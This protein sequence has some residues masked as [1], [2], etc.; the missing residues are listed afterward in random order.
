MKKSLR[1]SLGILATSLMLF[2]TLSANAAVLEPLEIRLGQP[3]SDCK[4][5][6]ERLGPYLT[7]PAIG[8]R[9]DL[10]NAT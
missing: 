3:Y 8:E 1:L 6:E 7:L 9:E 2:I 10:I 4:L 5:I